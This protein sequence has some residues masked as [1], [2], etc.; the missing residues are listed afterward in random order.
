MTPDVVR[1]AVEK[2]LGKVHPRLMR[3]PGDTDALKARIA[4]EPLVA[5]GFA[6]LME[7]A[8]SVKEMPLLE[9]VLTGRRLLSVSRECLSRMV[10]LGQAWRLTGDPQFVDRAVAEMRNVCRFPDW[11]PRHFLDTAE[12]SLAVSIGLDWFHEAISPDIRQEVARGLTDKGLDAGERDPPGRWVTATNNWSQVCHC[13]MVAAALTLMESDPDRA[14][15]VIQRMLVNIPGAMKVYNPDGGY[16]EGPM[17]WDYGTMFTIMLVD[18]LESVLGT[19]FGLSASPG[20]DQTGLYIQEVTGPLRLLFNYSDCSSNRYASSA[21]YWFA[22]RFGT[23][24]DPDWRAA[25]AE[26]WSDSNRSPRFSLE[27]LWLPPESR[28]G[29]CRLPLDWQDRGATPIAVH[30]SRWGDSRALFVGVK[31]GSPAHSHGQMDCGSFV[32][33]AD[34]VRW[35]LDLGSEDYHRVESRGLDLWS[36]G[37]GSDRWRIFR[38]NNHSHNTLT[39]DG[40]LQVASGAC[41]ITQFEVD[42]D[43]PYTRVELSPVYRG[44]AGRVVRTV[45]LPGRESVVI[46]DFLG[47]LRPGSQVRWGLMT[48]ADVVLNG[49]CPRLEQ[50]GESLRMEARGTM[51]FNWRVIDVSA[52]VA[53]FDSPNPGMRM[54]CFDVSA[55]ASGEV[56]FEVRLMPGSVPRRADPWWNAKLESVE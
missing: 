4:A 19:D 38:L 50:A 11:N 21:M 22:T 36:S 17:Y 51:I 28:S 20:F 33:D 34:G 18:T 53:D 25:L 35:A 31:A 37:Q 3:K 6:R 12:M 10:T 14:V 26:T 7:Q 23:P 32:L 9:P 1:A 13:G 47:G 56:S 55:P 49:A 15:R 42:S 43:T 16:P 41:P 45:I 54:V 44:Q 46:R 24:V 2:A 48:R 40:A 39:I 27:L 30:R 52:P 8:D 29:T 5:K